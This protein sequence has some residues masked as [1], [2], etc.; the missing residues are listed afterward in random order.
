MPSPIDFATLFDLAPGAYMVLDAGL[1]YV[2]ANAAYLEVTASE[3]DKLLGRHVF[4]AFPNDPKDPNNVP[5]QMLRK[6]FER[7]LATGERDH[8][9]YVPYRV[10]VRMPDGTTREE[11]RYWSA[12]HVPVRDAAGKVTHILQH[13]V[14]V[15]EMHRR[16]AAGAGAQLGTE[17]GV[18]SR[19]RAVQEENERLV[20]DRER[21]RVLFAQAPGFIAVLDGPDHVFQM[22]NDSYIRLVGGRAV[23]GK[24]VCDALPEVVEQGFIGILDRVR[25]SGEPFIGDGVRI[26]LERAAG[27][28]P[29]EVFVDFVYQPVR[30]AAGMVTGIFVQ[31]H[32]VTARLRAERESSDARRA[33]EAFAAELDEQSKQVSFALATAEKRIAELEAQRGAH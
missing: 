9:A 31:G 2:A 30:G 17:A 14:D 11:D 20:S 26:M 28:P 22:A 29:E 15:T 16:D 8:I 4:A 23:V 13:T 33:A 12:T 1:H 5:A 6:S 25:S 18:L 32:E 10:P 19:A 27:S 3:R 7:V 21:L 24:A